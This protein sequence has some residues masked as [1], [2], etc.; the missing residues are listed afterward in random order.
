MKQ[1]EFGKDSG[2]GLYNRRNSLHYLVPPFYVLFIIMTKISCLYIWK[3][4]NNQ[5]KSFDERRNKYYL[6]TNVSEMGV[7][8]I[9]GLSEYT[10]SGPWIESEI[11]RRG[12]KKKKETTKKV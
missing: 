2:R 5:L 8:C 12:K 3:E 10:Y 1:V 6:L 4:S 9:E 11:G 7:Q